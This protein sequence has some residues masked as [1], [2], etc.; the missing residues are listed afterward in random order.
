MM[1]FMILTSMIHLFVLTKSSTLKAAFR[2]SD[3]FK[4]LKVSG[5][6]LGLVFYSWSCWSD[7]KEAICSSVWLNQSGSLD[8]TVDLCTLKLLM[9]YCT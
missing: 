9:Y 6:G 4:V 3:A 5:L 2:R 7:D 1:V 8:Y